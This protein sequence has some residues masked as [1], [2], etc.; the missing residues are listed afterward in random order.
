MMEN[1]QVLGDRMT[2]RAALRRLNLGA[3][4]W[5]ERRVLLAAIASAIIAPVA[6]MATP[7][8]AKLVI[9]EV[10]GQ[11]HV[12]LL[13]PIALVAGLGVVIQAG[14]AYGAA[15]FGAL[16]G[17]RVATHLQQRL[18]QHTL[19]LPVRFFDE[20]QSGAHVT[21]IMTDTD[22]VRSLLGAGVL[23]LVSGALSGLVAFAVLVHIHWQLAVATTATLLLLTLGLSG[24]F[25]RL[26]PGFQAAAEL[27]A[28]L[29]GRLTQV[30]AGILVVKTCAAERREAH[31]FV[32]DTH[33]L[34]R[35]S[36]QANR[37]V[38]VLMGA[39]A[40]AMGGVSLMLLILGGQAVTAGAMTLGDLALFVVLAGLLGTPL[41]QAAAIGGDLGRALAALARIAEV[42]G[43]PTE[44]AAEVRMLPVPVR[45]P[46]VVFDNVS[47]AYQAGTPVLRGVSF[48]ARPGTVTALT[49]PNGAGKS[50]LLGLLMGID[51]PSTG[52]I[53]LDGRPLGEL[54][55]AEYRKSLGVV[56]QQGDL[57][58]GTIE[59]NIRYGR[60]GASAAE[61]RRAAR[62]AC[63]D[64]LV[65]ALPRGYETLVGERGVKLSGGQRQRIAIA[66]AILADPRALLLDE[67]GSQLDSESE[68]LLEEA[69]MALCS[70][71]T[72]FVVTHR[73]STVRRADQILVLRSGAI[74]ERVTGNLHVAS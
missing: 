57:F 72:T 1:G 28:A 11:G 31:L 58:E 49:G 25:R 50:T 55:L 32:R 36:V 24:L 67:A 60:P 3:L 15:H 43:L 74:V 18:Q 46:G 48:S 8:A 73:P 39:M 12:E 29:A 13:I 54:R 30:L 44:E 33:R 20:Q 63:C 61:F 2:L 59:E 66:R 26:H 22:Q 6:A 17:R 65:E 45:A 51:S 68:R 21:R 16:G 14:A 4:L 41:V 69:V 53:L 9:D 42:L 23:Q 5:R 52:R 47:Y 7:F 71:R 64:E 34:L 70:G 37:Q 10:I 38:S 27:Q 19:R 56:L 40:F 62:L 35:V